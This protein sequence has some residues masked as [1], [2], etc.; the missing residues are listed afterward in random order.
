MAA[1]ALQP[2]ARF[3]DYELL[4]R[5]ESGGMGEVWKASQIH[6]DQL[7]AIKFIKQHLLDDPDHEKRFLIEAKTLG[8]LEH[9]RIVPLY[10]VCEDQGRLALI[11]RFVDGE[12]LAR[13]IDR[14]GA[15]P[16]DLAL[17]CARDVLPALGMAHENGIVHRDIKPQNIL[18]DARERF[19]LSDF[20]IAVT[21]F[22]GRGTAEG[23]SLG[24]LHYMS[25]EQIE[26]P[27]WLDPHRGGQRSDIYSFGVV[28]FEML[29]GR[30]PFGDRQ[31]KG[32]RFAQ[33]A[34]MHC[35]VAPPRP[36][37]CNPNL[38]EALEVVVLQ[39]LE[40]NPDHRPQ[41]C[42]ELLRKLEAAVAREGGVRDHPETIV[43]QRPTAHPA[44]VL[45]Q[46]PGASPPADVP[47]GKP[48][49]S[50]RRARRPK[51]L[52]VAAG[53]LCAA[54][55][56]GLVLFYSGRPTP[57]VDSRP[58]NWQ[59]LPYNAEALDHC[60]ADSQCLERQAKR[61]RLRKVV[62]WASEPD[63]SPLLQDCM[64]LPPC[65]ERKKVRHQAT[66]PPPPKTLPGRS[67]QSSRAG[68]TEASPIPGA[69]GLYKQ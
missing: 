49:N 34:L 17:S 32:D 25:P 43:E 51:L 15:L 8:K 1:L 45:L 46:G 29:T 64:D 21:E 9:D 68:S 47:S 59:T 22:A 28:L 16:I 48:V 41:S 55:A 26:K 60:G 65:M 40:K 14:L 36:R 58:V 18:I 67:G 56:L 44:T 2:G 30:L 4:R 50:E 66:L 13:R 63:N 57:T 61:D 31:G 62:D 54:A 37:E 5:L 42:P 53:G 12:S 10:G 7:V 11:L 27:R 6:S 39:C 19:F 35:T 3:G 23:T 38:G 20:G 33:I 24:T 52:W 69:A